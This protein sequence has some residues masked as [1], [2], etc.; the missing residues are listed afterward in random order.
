MQGQANHFLKFAPDK[1]QYAI[2]RYQDE[3]RRLYKVLEHRLEQQ[4]NN[5]LVGNRP[6]IAD[7]TTYGWV[8]SVNV[9]GIDINEFPHVK[10]W[11]EKLGERDGVRRG[12]DV[13]RPIDDN[14]PCKVSA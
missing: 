5:C 1:N 9:A 2:Q 8:R 3:T 13:P 12:R 7:F 4:R 11:C 14:K 10:K 6:T